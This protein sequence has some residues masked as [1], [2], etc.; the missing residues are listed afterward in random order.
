[1]SY[2]TRSLK[3]S[4]VVTTQVT[5]TSSGGTVVNTG[6]RDWKADL[7]GC[8]D[9]CKTTLCGLCCPLCLA[10]RVSQRVGEHLCVP[11]CVPGGLIAIRTKMRLMLGIQ[12]SICNDCLAL[13]CCT[14]C[15]L[16]Q[17]QRELDLNNWPQ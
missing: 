3:M 17:M 16:C 2:T 15:A 4:Q 10:S 12:G 6:N 14:L 11:C 13:S 5:S 9:D 1:M 8:F 7:L